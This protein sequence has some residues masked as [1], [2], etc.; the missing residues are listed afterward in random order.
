MGGRGVVY[1]QLLIKSNKNTN[2]YYLIKLKTIQRGNRF[3]S[4]FLA[5]TDGTN[6]YFLI[7]HLPI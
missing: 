1:Q 4:I 2:K 7:T 5:D 6:I 3:V